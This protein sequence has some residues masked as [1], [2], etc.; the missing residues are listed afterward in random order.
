MLRKGNGGVAEQIHHVQ[1]DGE[2]TRSRVRHLVT[3][4][5]LAN[6]VN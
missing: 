1:S 4:D 2:M 3:V 6:Q 5:T